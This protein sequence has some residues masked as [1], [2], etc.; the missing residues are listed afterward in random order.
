MSSVF[1]NPI[2]IKSLLFN[3]EWHVLLRYSRVKK[4]TVLTCAA[5]LTAVATPAT[6]DVLGAK[7][8]VDYVYSD[9]DVNGFSAVNEQDNYHAYAAFE[10]FL[11]LLPNAL[12]E[13]AT[14][15]SSSVGFHQ[16]S[17]TGYYELLDNSLLS[18]DLGA[19]YSRYSDIQVGSDVSS[20]GSPHAYVAAEVML[21]VTNLSVFADVKVFGLQDVEGEEVRAGVRWALEL[22]V[23]LGVR[24]GYTMS[25]VTFDNA[26][27]NNDLK[28]ESDGWMLGLDARF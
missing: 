22:P 2:S 27:A 24:A 3:I 19:G 11:P 23:E 20:Q 1:I 26:L 13:Y 14:H 16:F 7:V 15:G 4:L 12:V 10:H 17:A 5:V 28:F 18:L 25:N 21:P 8:G 6:A 9:L